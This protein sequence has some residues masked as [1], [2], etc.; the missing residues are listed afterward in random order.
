MVT[1]SQPELSASSVKF[2]HSHTRSIKVRKVD[3][4]H[5]CV[6]T[7]EMKEPR[8]QRLIKSWCAYP[9]LEEWSP[10]EKKHMKCQERYQN[11]LKIQWKWASTW[12]SKLI[13]HLL[14]ADTS[15]KNRKTKNWG[16][17][18]TSILSY[19]KCYKNS[20]NWNKILVYNKKYPDI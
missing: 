5:K 20:S 4:L 14:L 10:A 19:K 3:W 2:C 18:L 7:S 15:Q 6:Y 11:S 16:K 13:L 9:K 8:L 17:S 12:H 1:P